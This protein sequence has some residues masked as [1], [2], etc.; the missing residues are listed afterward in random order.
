MTSNLTS[1]PAYSLLPILKLVPNYSLCSKYFH[2]TPRL[3]SDYSKTKRLL[4][5]S[6]DSQSNVPPSLQST[7]RLLPDYSQIS[8]KSLPMLK[9]FPDYSQTS[10]IT[11]RLK[12]NFHSQ[13]TSRLLPIHITPRLLNILRLFSDY[14]QTSPTFR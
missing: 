4:L 2:T 9:L 1:L 10:L 8:P 3:P 11:P 14:S 13:V 12:D 6:D 7:L 5:F